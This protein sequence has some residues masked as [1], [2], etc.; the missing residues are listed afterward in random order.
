MFTDQRNAELNTIK[1]L[2]MTALVES[3]GVQ[4]KNGH[5]KAVWRDDRRPSVSILQAGD[6]VWVWKD[7]GANEKGTNIDLFMK[8]YN[9]S[10]VQAVKALRKQT[11]GEQTFSFP[12]AETR[13]GYTATKKK[14]KP[15]WKILDEYD[16]NAKTLQLFKSY[17]RLRPKYVKNAGIKQ[18]LLLLNKKKFSLCG[19]QNMSG[20]WELYNVQGDFKSSTGKDITYISRGKNTLVIAESLIDAISCEQIKE[21]IFDLLV[22]NSVE[23]INRAVDFLSDLK[24]YS[25]I[26]IATD[27]DKAG[28]KAADMLLPACKTKAERVVGFNYNQ[29]KDPNDYL[30][31][32]KL[33]KAN[34][35]KKRKM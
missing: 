1:R 25:K 28:K 33:R 30:T 12:V 27:N 22:L 26:V 32:K 21:E 18:L 34:V 15:D 23:M 31:G 7:H 14:K 20:T 16:L 13:F 24:S 2:D 4:V 35:N 10:Y 8:L 3:A 5:F 11:L 19:H 17:R 6:G 29:Y 9:V